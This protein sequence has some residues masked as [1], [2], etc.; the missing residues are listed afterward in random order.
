LLLTFCP[1]GLVLDKLSFFN[2]LLSKELLELIGV[3]LF[4]ITSCP[5]LLGIKVLLYKRWKHLSHNVKTDAII[6]KT[7][8]HEYFLSFTRKFPVCVIK[9]SFL[10]KVH[11][12]FAVAI[13][14]DTWIRLVMK[15]V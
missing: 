2:C 4:V 7:I 1:F 13:V 6:L 9:I 12:D 3:L 10:V 15:S 14:F 8:G 11:P 5:T